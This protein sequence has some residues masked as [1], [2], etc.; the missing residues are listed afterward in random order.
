MVDTF[1]RLTSCMANI[2]IALHLKLEIQNKWF[3]LMQHSWFE[4]LDDDLTFI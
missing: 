2:F 4:L 3:P 1:Y